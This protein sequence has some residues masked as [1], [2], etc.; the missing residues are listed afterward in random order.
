MKCNSVFKNNRYEINWH[1]RTQKLSAHLLNSPPPYYTFQQPH[2]TN[3]IAEV[4]ICQFLCC[5]FFPR[6]PIYN[7]GKYLFFN[8]ISLSSQI[9]VSFVM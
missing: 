9:W 8:Q 7:L 4:P 2:D 1:S 6:F 3:Y 5:I